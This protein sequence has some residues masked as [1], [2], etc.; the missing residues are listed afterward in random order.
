MDEKPEVHIVGAGVAGLISALVLEKNGYRPTIWEASDEIGGRLRTEKVNG[1]SFDVGF[2]VLLEAYPKAKEYLDYDTLELRSFLPGASIYKNG[3]RLLI[4]DPFRDVS[5][6]MP[7]LTSS[8]GTFGDKLKI[9]RLNL[10]LKKK[11]IPDIFTT[12]EKTTLEYLR[13]FGFSDQIIRNFFKP[14][15]SGIFLE[16]NLETSS[17][18][19]EFV[20]KMFGEGKAL[21]PKDGIA[22]IPKQLASF[23]Q[24]TKINLNS[25]IEKIE[26]TTLYP[27]GSKKIDADYIILATAPGGLQ[28]DIRD[29]KAQ[30]RSC[31]NLYFKVPK[32]TKKKPIIGLLAQEGT[33]IN[34]FH[35]CIQNQSSDHDLLSVTV[36]KSH[37]LS[38]E[39]LVA[40]I[41]EELK[42]FC[43][44]EDATFIQYYKINKALPKLTDLQDTIDPTETQLTDTISLAG[45]HLLN[46]SLNAA[47]ESGEKAALGIIRKLNGFNE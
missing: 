10:K 39:K 30:W 2:Q 16:P 17:R 28:S 4:G 3:K 6:L 22:A 25:K 24:R 44:I 7:T 35:Y 33:L 46:G 31:M 38:N 37:S 47:M 26:G 23:L 43:M 29:Q 45:D 40:K 41:L 27:E 21:V 14:F 19:F 42:L 5:F 20:Y 34:N 12:K 9:F 13:D 8:V 36:V 32:T 15:F 18:M 1:Y 11:R